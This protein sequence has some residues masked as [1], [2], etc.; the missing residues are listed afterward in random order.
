MMAGADA[1]DLRVKGGF[2]TLRPLPVRSSMPTSRQ[3]RARLYFQLHIL[4]CKSAYGWAVP[5]D[6]RPALPANLR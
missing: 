2:E 1:A 6:E 5:R 3:S 4:A